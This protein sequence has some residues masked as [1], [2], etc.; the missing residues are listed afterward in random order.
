M[1]T[2]KTYRLLAIILA[3]FFTFSLSA[4]NKLVPYG[5]EVND[6]IQIEILA[7]EIPIEI[8]AAVG[9][10]LGERE[11]F[12]LARLHKDPKERNA[13]L[14]ASGDGEKLRFY[15]EIEQY[16]NNKKT[17][18]L[19]QVS[20]YTKFALRTCLFVVKA[21]IK[22]AGWTVLACSIFVTLAVHEHRGKLVIFMLYWKCFR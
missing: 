7:T 10:F 16:K 8:I 12:I 22:I 13:I 21:P 17:L 1:F 5:D 6:E 15:D 4:T 3:L 19:Q 2:H 11:L 20:L 18:R 14:K 9:T